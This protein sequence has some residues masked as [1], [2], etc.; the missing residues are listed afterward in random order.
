MPVNAAV[1]NLGYDA[2]R[3]V[4]GPTA[5]SPPFN[6]VDEAS[7]VRYGIRFLRRC[8]G[9]KAYTGRHYRVQHLLSTCSAVRCLFRSIVLITAVVNARGQPRGIGVTQRPVRTPKSPHVLGSAE[10]IDFQQ[11]FGSVSCVAYGHL[12]SL[13]S[14]ICFLATA[15]PDGCPAGGSLRVSETLCVQPRLGRDIGQYRAIRG[16]RRRLEPT[17]PSN[18]DPPRHLSRCLRCTRLPKL[19][20]IHVYGLSEQVVELRRRFLPPLIH[21]STLI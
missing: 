9:A 20:H 19:H 3:L 12:L 1:S 8:T 11:R 4:L 6:W 13:S 21:P 16:L 17:T 7:T 5:T 10:D 14:S 2:I 18:R 15:A